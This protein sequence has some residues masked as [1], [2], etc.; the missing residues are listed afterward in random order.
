MRALFLLALS[1]LAVSVQTAAQQAPARDFSV[2]R[3]VAAG[4]VRGRVVAEES[5]QALIRAR[6]RLTLADG[7]GAIDPVFTDADGR[8]E[9]I[10]LL[11][12]HYTLA[13]TKTGYVWGKL[14]AHQ[15]DRTVGFDLAARETLDA[16]DVRMVKAAAISGRVD[17]DRSERGWHRGGAVHNR[18]R[19]RLAASHCRQ[20][21]P[22][23]SRLAEDGR[24]L[25]VSNL[26]LAAFSIHRSA[27]G[28]RSVRNFV[29]F[30]LNRDGTF[31]ISNVIGSIDFSL[32][33]P[34]GWAIHSVMHQERNLLDAPLEFFGGE[35]LTNVRI[36]ITTRF[37]VR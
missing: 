32:N 9:F 19:R 13:V 37:I 11:P 20:E 7:R 14:G 4:T 3:T 30:T 22:V 2:S 15:V 25:N 5:Q 34:E 29:P 24:P 36:A 23:R 27:G 8:F 16:L 31:D 12:G 33:R 21:S 26:Q 6:D 28:G 17:G 1:L 10:G 18:N 35:E